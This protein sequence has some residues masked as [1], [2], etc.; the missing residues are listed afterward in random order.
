MPS[1]HSPAA[2]QRH[3][4]RLG[5]R[6]FFVYLVLYVGFVLLNA[7]S[8]DVMEWRP[9]GGINLA[10]LYGFGLILAA[11]A[12]AFLYGMLAKVARQDSTHEASR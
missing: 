3:N 11:L 7:Y 4:S 9:W 8:P 5:L 10:L 6:L 2:A 1:Q 12:L